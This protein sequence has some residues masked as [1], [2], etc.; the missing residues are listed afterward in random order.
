MLHLQIFL[1]LM[2]WSD[3]MIVDLAQGPHSVTIS[4]ERGLLAKR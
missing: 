4:F 3:Y 1:A 2:V